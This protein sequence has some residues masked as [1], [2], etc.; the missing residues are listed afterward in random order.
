MILT[1]VMAQEKGFSI[2]EKGF[3]E[4][5]DEQKKRGREAS[6]D[7]FASVNI[8]LN[9]LNSFELV[10]D[11]KSEFIGYDELKSN[12]KIIGIKKKMEMISLS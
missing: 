7:K 8:S 4:L 2:D 3:N 10:G 9:D 5:M 12:S 6:K 1:N 11:K